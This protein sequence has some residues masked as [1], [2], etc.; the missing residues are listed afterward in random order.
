MSSKSGITGIS[1]RNQPIEIMDSETENVMGT[2][3]VLVL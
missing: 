3:N 2:V 1:K